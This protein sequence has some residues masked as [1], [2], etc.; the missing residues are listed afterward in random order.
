MLKFVAVGMEGS[1][2]SKKKPIAPLYR[3]FN[4]ETQIYYLHIISILLSKATCFF[5]K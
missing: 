1:R 3:Y 4:Q 5:L 2:L